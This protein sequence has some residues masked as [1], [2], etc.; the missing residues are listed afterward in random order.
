MIVLMYTCHIRSILE[1]AAPVFNSFL[2]QGDS[3]MIEKV[4]EKFLRV[5]F[6]YEKTYLELCGEADLESLEK[7][8]KLLCINFVRKEMKKCDP[9]FKWADK[10]ATR[11]GRKDRLVI[12]M[13]RS[14]IHFNTPM[15]ALARMYNESIAN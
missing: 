1:Y 10:S 14:Q 4:Q 11:S 7:R 2:T 6:G 5:I 13:A 9:I 3:I 8:R 12:P 15:I